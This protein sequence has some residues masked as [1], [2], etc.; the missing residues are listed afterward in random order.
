MQRCLL[1]ASTAENRQ[2]PS[3]DGV[4]VAQRGAFSSSEAPSQQLFPQ[5]LRH[6]CALMGL[7]LHPSAPWGLLTPPLRGLGLLFSP[8]D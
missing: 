2:P 3:G 1:Q 7:Y 5:W 4:S 6:L 8:G